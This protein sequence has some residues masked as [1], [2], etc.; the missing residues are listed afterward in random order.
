MQDLFTLLARLTAL[1]TP[2]GQEGNALP[3]FKEVLEPLGASVSGDRFGNIKAVFGSGDVFLD[4]HID[5]IGM[6][7]TH[8]AE[9]GFLRAAPV[10]R[11]DGRTLA[12]ADFTV[13]GKQ[14]LFA[15]VSATPPH[16]LTA[17]K[18]NTVPAPE[19]LWLDTGLSEQEAREQVQPGDR[20]LFRGQTERL[21]DDTVTSPYLDN[22]VGCAVLLRTAQLL[23]EQNALDN[24]TLCFSAQEEAGLRGAAP[25]IF[26]EKH[27]RVY[28]IDVS[29]GEA[30]GIRAENCGKM[31]GGAMVGFS[32]VLDADISRALCQLAEDENLPCQREIMGAHT[33]TNADILSKTAGGFATAMLSVPIR[34]MHTPAETVRLS[35]IEN[36]AALLAA[37]IRKGV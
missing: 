2:S 4:A 29:F 10:G 20:I 15:T 17:E 30:P 33:G 8:V 37:A 34:N 16:L 6:V 14:P 7:V 9:N 28:V 24:L 27:A 25:S 22:S 3:F 5:K 23:Q 26:E 13:L 21:G 32:P 18:T 36:T 1:P 35:D 19:E 12:A 31:G 11:L